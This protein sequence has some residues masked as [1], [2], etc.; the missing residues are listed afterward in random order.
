MAAEKSKI[1]YRK[2]VL[3]KPKINPLSKWSS[4]TFLVSL[5]TYFVYCSDLDRQSLP[6]IDKIRHHLHV[7]I[8]EVKLFEI[9]IF[10]HIASAKE[11]CG[12]S[13]L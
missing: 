10:A 5:S 1:E 8:F 9:S 6:E 7:L 2:V 4:I 12:F 11:V 3:P 13:R